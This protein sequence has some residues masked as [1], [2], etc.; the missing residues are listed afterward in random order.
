MYLIDRIAHTN[1]WT[2]RPTAE[3]LFLCLGG[4]IL[5]VTGPAPAAGTL[6][7]VAASCCALFAARIPPRAYA[8]VLALPIGF[9]LAG[10]PV[11][12]VSVDFSG[13]PLLAWRADQWRLAAAL[14]G[15]AGGAVSCLTLLI[16]TTP[17][18]AMIP[19]LRRLGVPAFLIEIM[20]LTYRLIFVVAETAA[21]GYT[22]QAAR[23]GYSGWRQSLRSL[24][25]LAA[26]LFQRS[27]TRARHMETGLAA[28]GFDGNLTVLSEDAPPVSAVRCAAIGLLLAGVF[29]CAWLSEGMIH[30]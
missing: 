27:M 6:M 3:K 24:G 13:G 7:F 22:A 23:L 5:C 2:R 10:L 8:A 4:L 14:V 26:A 30:V 12:M 11:L 20:L 15:R 19:G 17:V 1:R 21:A 18:H 29:A 16:L 28:R 25:V 9:L